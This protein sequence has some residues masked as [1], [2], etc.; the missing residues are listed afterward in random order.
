MHTYIPYLFHFS[1]PH[2]EPLDPS[3]FT[4]ARPRD[5]LML[6]QF[7]YHTLSYTYPFV[8]G[9][10][11][12]SRPPSLTF[13]RLYYLSYACA[14]PCVPIK[15]HSTI[16]CGYV[17]LIGHF[18][19]YSLPHHSFSHNSILRQSLCIVGCLFPPEGGQSWIAPPHPQVLCSSLPPF[20]LHLRQ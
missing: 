1:T 8:K 5:W 3:L 4:S 15:Y 11:T 19:L 6:I 13:I 9:S 14:S 20:P 10:S 17:L 18:E 16:G 7:R 2:R 12:S